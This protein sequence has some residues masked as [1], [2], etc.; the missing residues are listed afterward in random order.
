M[1]KLMLSSTCLFLGVLY[2]A[3]CGTESQPYYYGNV[4]PGGPGAP[5]Q[6]SVIPNEA[7]FNFWM[8]EAQQT[9]QRK[10]LAQNMTGC[11]LAKDPASN[12]LFFLVSFEDRATQSSLTL[13][14]ITDHTEL[15]TRPISDSQILVGKNSGII[16]VAAGA[17]ASFHNG[18]I[19]MDRSEPVVSQCTVEYELSS[20]ALKG[21]ATCTSLIN[22]V[23]QR[24]SGSISFSCAVAQVPRPGIVA[25]GPVQGAQPPQGFQQPQQP[26]GPQPTPMGNNNNAGAVVDP[27][28]ILNPNQLQSQPPAPG[29]K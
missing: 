6:A 26:Q 27:N 3:G 2:L 10:F 8:P 25:G 14:V 17:D 15:G 11:Q 5:G 18:K 28:P 1:R 9:H 24:A 16:S 4:P 22:G 12:H 7:Q 23:N 20:A 29:I 13:R 19:L 21:E